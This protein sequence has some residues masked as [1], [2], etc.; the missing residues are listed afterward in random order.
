MLRFSGAGVTDVGSARVHNED[1]SYVSPYVALVA[2]GVGGA[3]A[4]EVASA[5]AASV[6]AAGVPARPRRDPVAVLVEL[7]A[8]VVRRLHEEATTCPDRAGMATTL[9]ALVTDG[10]RVALAHAGDSRAYL[11]RDGRLRRVSRDHTYVQ[12]LLDQGLITP[13]GAGQHPWR[14]VVTRSLPGSPESGP[15]DVGEVDVEVGDRL[16]VCSDGLTDVVPETRI[17][18]V[19][20]LADAR[21]AAAR[22]VGDALAAG[23]P[24]NVTCLVLDVLDGPEVAGDGVALGAFEAYVD[25]AAEARARLATS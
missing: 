17:A 8:Q 3:A 20:E 9:T 7:V 10:S 12:G 5:T 18:E 16:L 21:S 4:G 6:L 24:D 22:L 23:G 13:E 11:L 19:L 15:P 14:H 2:D 1:S 25:H